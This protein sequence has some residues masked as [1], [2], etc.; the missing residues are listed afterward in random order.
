MKKT[1]DCFIVWEDRKK[2][3][4]VVVYKGN[5]IGVLQGVFCTP[6]SKEYFVW[7]AYCTWHSVEGQES[8][9]V[10][11]AYRTG[12]DECAL[13]VVAFHVLSQ[14]LIVT[15]VVEGSHDHKLFIRNYLSKFAEST[16]QNGDS[17]PQKTDKE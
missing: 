3:T 8:T 4:G 13:S 10:E 1:V 17:Q 2:S 14:C 6:K 16:Q 5:K 9:T 15:Q 7:S 11:T 12:A